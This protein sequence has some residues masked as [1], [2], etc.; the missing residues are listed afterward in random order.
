MTPQQPPPTVWE[1]LIN[2]LFGKKMLQQSAQ[3]GAPQAPQQTAIPQPQNPAYSQQ[4][5]MQQNQDYADS[6]RR[7]EAMKQAILSQQQGKK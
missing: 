4:D 6:L 7:Q 5:M 2:F 3:T 1:N